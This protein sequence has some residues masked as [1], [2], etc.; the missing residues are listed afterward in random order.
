MTSRVPLLPAPD[1]AL[2]KRR[3][4]SSKDRSE[5]PLMPPTN[6]RVMSWDMTRSLTE[7]W[8]P[9]S[10]WTAREAQPLTGSD[11]ALEGKERGVRPAS[12]PR[13]SH[14]REGKTKAS[15]EARHE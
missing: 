2:K 10:A 14:T 9:D 6:A 13:A 11:A 4:S 1:T 5:L 8:P 15:P 7:T 12:T 3:R